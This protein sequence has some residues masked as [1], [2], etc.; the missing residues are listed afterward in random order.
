MIHVLERFIIFAEDSMFN[1]LRWWIEN[2]RVLSVVK[3]NFLLSFK[4]VHSL[5][6][7][8]GKNDLHSWDYIL[9]IHFIKVENNLYKC[10]TF[11]NDSILSGQHH[12][13]NEN[14]IHTNWIFLDESTLFE[15]CY[16]VVESTLSKRLVLSMVSN[17]PHWMV[18]TIL[19]FFTLFFQLFFELF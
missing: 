6:V 19:V 16:A 13:I 2:V 14:I 18:P 1:V 11:F 10:K 15:W 3:K 12:R 7:L 17:F 4:W 5:C 9:S 8:C